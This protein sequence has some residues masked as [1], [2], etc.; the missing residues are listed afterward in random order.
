MTAAE[1]RRLDRIA[2]LAR[3]AAKIE[4]ELDRS[5]ARAHAAGFSLRRLEAA[6]GIPRATLARR[7]EGGQG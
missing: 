7:L 6:T 5:L 4:R 1:S 2:G 3:E